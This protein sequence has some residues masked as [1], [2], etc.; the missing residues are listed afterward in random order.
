MVSDTSV[1]YG[2]IAF[3]YTTTEIPNTG[4]P[5]YAIEANE[6]LSAVP[7]PTSC[8]AQGKASTVL[9]HRVYDK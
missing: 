4:K 1:K 5:N 6:D 8:A 7:A 9:D 2:G 3:N